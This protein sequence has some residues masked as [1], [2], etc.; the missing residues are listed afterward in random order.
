MLNQKELFAVQEGFSHRI[1]KR[2]IIVIY[3]VVAYGG[4][5][6]YVDSSALVKHAL[7]GGYI[8][9]LANAN[10]VLIEFKKPTLYRHRKLVK[11]RCVY[12]LALYRVKACYGKLA[13]IIVRRNDANV[14]GGNDG[15]LG[16]K[17]DGEGAA[18]SD[19]IGGLVIIG[20]TNHYLISV[21]N[22]A[23]RGVHSIGSSML[24]VRANNKHR[25]RIQPGLRSKILSHKLTP[26]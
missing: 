14:V 2:E 5:L 8:N 20:K 25:H 11:Q 24:I 7:T 13:W 21:V 18:F 6:F 12:V 19:V 17:A 9:D 16:G 1:S 3:A 22:T 15:A 10:S 4:K 26:L 23:P